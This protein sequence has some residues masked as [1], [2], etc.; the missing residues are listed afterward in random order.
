MF[1]LGAVRRENISDSS[2]FLAGEEYIPA[3]EVVELV[4]LVVL[5]L[6]TVTVAGVRVTYTMDGVT[7]VT[8]S[9]S[10]KH[11]DSSQS[12]MTY[13]LWSLWKLVR[14]WSMWRS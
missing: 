2:E 12:K 3:D 13:A 4:E 8:M 7:I 1:G 5:V 11:W 14:W 10:K 9:W 6:V